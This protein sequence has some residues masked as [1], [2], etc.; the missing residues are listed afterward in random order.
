[1]DWHEEKWNSE[2]ASVG[3]LEEDPV[4]TI[5]SGP[6]EALSDFIHVGAFKLGRT[7]HWDARAGLS[8]RLGRDGAP[9]T[10]SERPRPPGGLMYVADDDDILVEA[11]AASIETTAAQRFVASGK[12]FCLV[13][14]SPKVWRLQVAT[15]ADWEAARAAP[16]S[17]SQEESVLN[18]ARLAV[19]FELAQEQRRAL[20]NGNEAD[21]ATTIALYNRLLD[22]DAAG[23]DG[24]DPLLACEPLD[25]DTCQ[26]VWA[27]MR[28]MADEWRAVRHPQAVEEEEQSVPF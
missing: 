25:P 24:G 16:P 21:A 5:A 28:T 22:Q 3:E 27:H 9:A 4:E 23:D 2:E 18:Q 17:E 20:F 11:Q 1:M 7:S 14:P 10:T 26:A 13:E 12:L 19:A 6:E 15:L 8:W